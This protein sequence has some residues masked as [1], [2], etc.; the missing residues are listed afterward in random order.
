MAR[1]NDK[2]GSRRSEGLDVRG[3]GAVQ[4]ALPAL[5]PTARG[6][7]PRRADEFAHPSITMSPEQHHRNVPNKKGDRHE[8]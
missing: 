6:P 1:R 3:A 5:R 8:K 2:S 7:P 4:A